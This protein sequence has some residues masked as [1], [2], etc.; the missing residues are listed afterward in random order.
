MSVNFCHKT[1]L[2]ELYC[3]N[4]KKPCLIP[5]YYDLFFILLLFFFLIVLKVRL[6]SHGRTKYDDTRVLFYVRC[7]ST[8]SL[9]GVDTSNV[10]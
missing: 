9:T 10:C 7:R 1:E 5:F 3:K 2:H 4:K 8:L 6:V